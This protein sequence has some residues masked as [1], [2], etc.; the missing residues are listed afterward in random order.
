MKSFVLL[1]LGWL[2][3]VGCHRTIELGNARGEARDGEPGPMIIRRAPVLIHFKEDKH[4]FDGLVGARFGKGQHGEAY[5]RNSFSQFH[6]RQGWVYL[7]G[8]YPF[9]RT[10]FVATL[11]RGTTYVVETDGDVQRVYLLSQGRGDQVNVDLVP[12]TP[13]AAGATTSLKLSDQQYVTIAKDGAGNYSIGA[14][15]PIRN[16][17]TVADFITELRAE[18]QAA[19]L[20]GWPAN[21]P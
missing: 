20:G 17:L 21:L 15:K 9:S 3:L 2:M 19:N 4:D 13:T 11:A 18:V 6:L 10:D 1:M 5:I 8:K 14:P 7:F 12:G 16:D